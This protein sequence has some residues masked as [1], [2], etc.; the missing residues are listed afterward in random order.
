MYL[1]VSTIKIGQDRQS[2]WKKILDPSLEKV[3]LLTVK[4]NEARGE[5]TALNVCMYIFKRKG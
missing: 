5:G 3:I 4:L 2:D 1:K